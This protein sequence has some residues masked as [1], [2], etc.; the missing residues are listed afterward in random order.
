VRRRKRIIIIT[1]VAGLAA[2]SAAAVGLVRARD[3]PAGTGYAASDLCT[4]AIH[5]GVP[6]DEVRERYTAP[7]VYPLGLMWSV[8]YRPGTR[9][10]V[11]SILP[12]LQH[13]RVAVYRE[14]LGCTV[15]PPGTQPQRVL[16]Q[17]FEALPPQPP[18]PRRWPL[19]EAAAESHRLSDAA[20]T[21]LERH[22]ARLFGEDD[23]DP[24][25]RRNTTALL[26]A[27]DGHLVFERYG[28]GLQRDQP[29]LGWSMTKTLTALI[30]G[31]LARD[32]KLRLD[33]PVRLR[34][35][36]GTPKAAI[37]WRQLLNMAPG[38]AWFEGY[39]GASDTTEMLFSQADQG[40]FAADRP[41]ESGPGQVFNYSTG[42]SN[43]AM[44]RIRELLGGSHQAVYD[45]YQRGL[46]VPLG[47]RSGAIEP[48]VSGTPIGGA[49]GVLRAVDWL[50]LGQLV[51]GDGTWHGT[52]ILTPEYLAFMKA[53]SPASAGYGGSIW[54]EA[55]E[56]IDPALRARLP[57][58]MVWFAGVMG[59]FMVV[60]PS[61]QLIV[62]RMGVSLTGNME[63]DTTR[64]LVFELAADLS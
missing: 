23:D 8:D 47:M 21:A 30:A 11:Q 22:G 19:G 10:T 44:Y 1:A 2:V 41:L 49:R 17:R 60:V 12:A 13:P 14:G 15:V 31:V 63:R 46:F 34:R 55:S 54:R 53:P 35:W 6:F 27:R 4:R 36:A 38:L 40:R 29:Q 52:T 37:T 39:A 33:D 61:A 25:K 48:D 43:I 56:H 42:F 24:R 59:Q 18:D 57:D 45:Y 51:A 64:D 20:R 26:V 58:D 3:I 32:G 28:Q 7:R 5:M 16:A 50:R 62:L 9:A